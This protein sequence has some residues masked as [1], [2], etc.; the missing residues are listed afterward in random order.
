MKLMSKDGNPITVGMW[1]QD[2]DGIFEVVEIDEYRSAPVHAKE[3]YFDLDEDG[4]PLDTYTLR[5]DFYW[6]PE[7]VKKMHG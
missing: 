4:D 1:L 5:S 7:E 3:V 2:V 6:T